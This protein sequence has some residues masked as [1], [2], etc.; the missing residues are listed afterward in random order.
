M[1]KSP[2][3]IASVALPTSDEEAVKAKSTT[4]KK[5]HAL[6]LTEMDDFNA[7]LDRRGI[8]YL[9]RI[10]PRMGPAKISS[11][12]GTFGTVTRVYLVEEDKALRK[13][14][15]KESGK[16][17]CGKRY[18][19]GWVEFED[20]AVAKKVGMALNNTPI[21]NHKRNVHYG[22]YWSIKYVSKFKWSHLTE[23]VAYERRMREQKVRLEMTK[24]RKENQSFAE[25]VE[26]G[27]VMDK[28]EQRRKRKHVDDGNGSESRTTNDTKTFRRSFK[29]TT[30][31][32]QSQDRSSKPLILSSL[33]AR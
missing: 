4:N 29:Q 13:R 14:R 6:D 23:K 2:K 19:E 5:K 16:S 21:T 28:I 26:A 12:L 27:K 31:L 15:R 30:P 10:H 33:V 18:R 22:D 17:H 20:K 9:A 7:K 11:L 8:V 3:M 25:L 32:D 24:A 1:Q